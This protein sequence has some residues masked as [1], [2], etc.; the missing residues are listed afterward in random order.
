M[1]FDGW[2]TA[3]LVFI[4]AELFY[5]FRLLQRR[6][7]PGAEHQILARDY[8]LVE[9]L[10]LREAGRSRLELG[11]AK[12]PWFQIQEPYRWHNRKKREW[13]GDTLYFNSDDGRDVLAERKFEVFR[14][15]AP[16]KQLYDSWVRAAPYS[17]I[18]TEIWLKAVHMPSN[19]IASTQ[20]PGLSNDGHIIV[21][22]GTIVHV[23]IDPT[24]GRNEHQQENTL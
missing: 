7:D 2:A 22:S 23:S 20:M 4:A 5:I 6:G 11:T 1:W 12:V 17:E 16:A 14:D 18:A 24:S 3:V 9:K 13:I 8:Y 19:A 15:Y 21:A 10:E